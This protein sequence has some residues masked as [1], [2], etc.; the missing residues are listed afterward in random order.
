MIFFKKGNNL[1]KLFTSGQ[2]Y[3]FGVV[4]AIQR[5]N[6]RHWVGFINWCL[7]GDT[8]GI[9]H[10]RWSDLSINLIIFTWRTVWGFDDDPS[11][12]G[13]WGKAVVDSAWT[14]WGL[15]ILILL[16]P[17]PRVINSVWEVSC[18]FLNKKCNFFSAVGAYLTVT[19]DLN[20]WS[21]QDSWSRTTALNYVN[22]RYTT[23]LDIN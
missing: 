1:L 21:I 22:L 2:F 16:C 3:G 10:H 6:K 11:F 23:K 14:E 20:A 17:F 4:E 5:W 15:N 7:L 12:V 18:S 13:D 19:V 9:P 8:V